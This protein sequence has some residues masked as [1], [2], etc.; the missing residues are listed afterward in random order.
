MWHDGFLKEISSDSGSIGWWRFWIQRDGGTGEKP[1]AAHW[2]GSILEADDHT[3]RI[4]VWYIYIIIYMLT[5][6]VY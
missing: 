2:R 5:F 6:G 3:H 1:W 4:H